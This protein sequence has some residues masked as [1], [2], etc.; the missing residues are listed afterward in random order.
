MTK[1][2]IL[3]T[4]VIC[5]A[6]CSH[7]QWTG[8][9]I[10]SESSVTG[11]FTES[12]NQ[13]N[14]NSSGVDIW[15]TADDF[16]FVYQVVC[17]DFQITTKMESMV[18][19]GVWAKAGLMIRE[20]LTPESAYGMI[21]TFQPENTT[22]TCFQARTS[23]GTSSQSLSCASVNTNTWYRLTREGSLITT[24]YSANGSDWTQI[25]SMEMDF[26]NMVFIGLAATSFDASTIGNVVFSETTFTSN[27]TQSMVFWEAEAI[28]D[29]CCYSIHED[30]FT[31]AGNYLKVKSDLNQPDTPQNGILSYAFTS[32][33]TSNQKLWARIKGNTDGDNKLWY[34]LNDGAWQLFTLPSATD[35]WGWVALSSETFPVSSGENTFEMA[36]NTPDFS[37]DRFVITDDLDFIPVGF[38]LSEVYGPEI[39][40]SNNGSDSNS[41]STPDQPWKTLEKLNSIMAGLIP[42][43]TVFFKAGDTFEGEINV[44]TSGTPSDPVSF[45]SYGEGEKPVIRGAKTVSGWQQSDGHI[46]SAN[47][48][49]GKPAQLYVDDIMVHIARY[50][51]QEEG[52]LFN[53]SIQSDSKTGFATGQLDQPQEVIE[54]STVRFRSNAWTWEYRTVAE[55][56]NQEIVFDSP[57][58]YEIKANFGYYLDGKLAYLDTSNEWVYDAAAGKIYIWFPE[59]KNPD[60]TT[61]YASVYNTGFNLPGN[62]SNIV[63]ENLHIDKHAAHAINIGS[64]A[65]Q[66]VTVLNNTISHIHKTAISL[67]GSNLHVAS[68]TMHDLVNNAIYGHNLDD[69]N[70]SFNDIRR[71]GL[72]FAYG[73]TGQHNTCGI[74][75]LDS[76]NALISQNRLDSIG[77][78]GILAYCDNSIIENNVVTYTG[79]TLN[80]VGALY[81]WGQNCKN[82]TWRNNIGMYTYGNRIATDGINENSPSSMGFGLYFDNNSSYL[83]AENNTIAF[84]GS[85]MHANAGSNNHSFTGNISY[86]NTSNQLLYSNFAYLGDGPI[87]GMKAEENIL[88]ASNIYNRVFSLKGTDTYDMGTV[89]ANYYMNPW[90]HEG[91]MT[92]NIQWS[93]WVENMNDHNSK[94]SFYVLDQ[95]SDDD[96]SELLIN[97]TG[98]TITVE[99]SGSYVDI[100]N[101]PVSS[102]EI[103]PFSSKVVIRDSGFTYRT[104]TD[105]AVADHPGVSLYPNPVKN[106]LYLENLPDNVSSIE[107]IDSQGR[108]LQLTDGEN[109]SG[110]IDT[111]GLPNGVFILKIYTPKEIMILKFMKG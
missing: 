62:E 74:Y 17:G 59:G 107:C 50:P 103:A 58:Q 13:I 87:H 24:A 108:V 39:Y 76:R 73:Q 7:A 31:S 54:G 22:G 52:F 6:F 97:D 102:V 21:S 89:D 88:F 25:T 29:D 111:S 71:V 91:L 79:L 83:I 43:T 20:N 38:G 57:A 33:V 84:N 49:Q 110:K 40:L 69:V 68:N 101:N 82:S 36:Y 61:V 98:N 2:L 100:D 47:W 93:T 28:F 34:R 53:T 46:Y 105:I 14:I 1:K 81:C 30:N 67:K 45:T 11:S 75:L 5:I 3:I 55:Y 18:N 104:T 63:I 35:S 41:G 90:D 64:N 56:E 92:S 80:D 86:K 8:L 42:G 27:P 70:I 94:L 4:A 96:P 9:H 109:F 85:G 65:T 19:T 37:I 10:G 23:S 66:N 48:T 106:Y 99:L 78:G 44:V 16:Y 26:S 72:N 12:G 60:N 51:N 32:C 15:N 77:Y 95:A